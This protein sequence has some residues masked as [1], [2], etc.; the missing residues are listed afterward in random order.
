MPMKTGVRAESFPKEEV[1]RS[2]PDRFEKMVRLHGDRV[3]VKTSDRILTYDEL[4]R[5]ANRVA[6]T[7]LPY[8]ASKEKPVALLLDQGPAFIAALLGVL[9]TGN[10]YVPLDPAFPHGRCAYMLEDSTSR[11]I[12]TDN[13]GVSMAAR[14]AGNVRRVINVDDLWNGVSDENLGLALSPETLACALYTSGSTGQPK[15]V[16][17]SHSSVLHMTMNFTHALRLEKDDRVTL[18][19]SPTTMGSLRTIFLALLNGAA[20]LTFDIKKEGLDHFAAWLQSEKVTILRLGPTAF[21]HFIDTL[22]GREKFPDIRM[23]YLGGEPI[24]KKDAE[25]HKKHFSENC[26]LVAGLGATETGIVLFYVV[27]KQ[28]EIAG[29]MVPLGFPA[30]DTEV[31]LLDEAGDEVG[32]AEIGE[33]AVKSRYLSCGYWR[34]PALTKARF[35]TGGESSLR[36]Y[37]TGDLGRRLPDGSF[38]HCGRADFQVK[39]R[40]YRVEVAEI[41]MALIEYGGIKEAVVVGRE[42]RLGGQILVAYAVPVVSAALR[43]GDL[44][45]FLKRKLSDYM[46]PS[47]FV[48]LDRLPLLPNGKIDRRALPAPS[49]R[50]PMLDSPFVAPRDPIEEELAKIWAQVL[51]LDDVG[52]HDNFFELGGHSLAAARVISQ[53]IKRFQLEI[54]LP[55][56]FQSPTIAEMARVIADHEGRKLKEQDLHSLLSELEA[57]TDEQAQRSLDAESEPADAK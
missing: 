48:V 19:Y 29:S 50:R 14:L 43:V 2:I 13:K 17:H 40:G 5:S 6:G 22:S 54:P 49:G 15:G 35:L 26:L 44:R 10:F 41:E 24:Y 39:I 8:C 55:F 11:L 28:T 1:E 37:R 25:S 56:L 42:D 9:K 21:R 20:V 3:A 46:I 4:N 45:S 36:I 18:P 52:I 31:L 16:L 51:S 53:V 12:L 57:L 47:A 27:D 32:L 33:I 23:I 34:N 7:I 30:E 38:V